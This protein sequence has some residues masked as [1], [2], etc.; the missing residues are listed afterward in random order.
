[1]D[2]GFIAILFTIFF[3]ISL[4]SIVQEKIYYTLKYRHTQ[5]RLLLNNRNILNQEKKKFSGIKKTIIDRKK[6]PNHQ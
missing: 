2:V 5:K 1:M 4:C 3:L 6:Y